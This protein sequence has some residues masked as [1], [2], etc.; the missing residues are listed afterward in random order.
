[1]KV[2]LLDIDVAFSDVGCR[3]GP[4]PTLETRDAIGYKQRTID[5]RACSGIGEKAGRITKDA[6]V[7]PAASYLRHF[8]INHESF[9]ILF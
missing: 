6:A 1:M 9:L 3:K 4:F 8:V 5:S 2:F 7:A